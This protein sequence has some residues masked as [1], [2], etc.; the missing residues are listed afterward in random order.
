MATFK[1]LIEFC[2]AP[3]S[4]N[5]AIRQEFVT[6]AY[7]FG[8]AQVDETLQMANGNLNSVDSRRTRDNYFDPDAVFKNGPGGC[9]R[10]AM[11]QKTN[12]V[13]GTYD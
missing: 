13:S 3:E 4:D 12:T 1:A 6:A 9:L 2:L 5:P 11:M 7:R 8:H 10:G